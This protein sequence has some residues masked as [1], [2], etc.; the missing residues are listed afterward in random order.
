MEAANLKDKGFPPWP[1]QVG[2]PF[3]EVSCK[4]ACFSIS[5]YMCLDICKHDTVHTCQEA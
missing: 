3:S 2:A 4:R 1:E 5:F